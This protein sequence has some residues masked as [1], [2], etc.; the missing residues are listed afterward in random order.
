M[1]TGAKPAD[2]FFNPAL[3]A[4]LFLAAALLFSACGSENGSTSENPDGDSDGDIIEAE[5]ETEADGDDETAPEEE[6]EAESDGD[7]EMLESEN[8]TEAEAADPLWDDWR[9][10]GAAVGKMLGVA[11][12]M[13]QGEGDNEDRNF[14]FARYDELGG[15][16]MRQH[17]RWDDLEPADDDWR[18]EEVADQEIRRAHV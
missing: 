16:V 12:H 7:I 13:Y 11:T 5:P 18:F 9:A 15:A 3:F 1:K 8:E 4:F 17:M 2:K 14:E 10:Q 6:A